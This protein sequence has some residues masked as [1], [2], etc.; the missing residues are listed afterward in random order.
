MHA[1]KHAC[2]VGRASRHESSPRNGMCVCLHGSMYTHIYSRLESSPRNRYVY[3]C[4]RACIHTLIISARVLPGIGTFLYVCI[5]LCI[6]ACTCICVHVCT[7]QP[8]QAYSLIYIHIY[9]FIYIYIYTHTHVCVP[10]HNTF[11]AHGYM[12]V[13]RYFNLL[14][15]RNV[16]RVFAMYV[17]SL[18][19][20]NMDTYMHV[21][22]YRRHF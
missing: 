20:Q 3:V 14:A 6:H 18:Y 4:M 7:Y 10:T 8:R 19:R 15:P 16:H 17:C 9:T 22:A 21:H 12:H 2:I 1:C 5:Y 11:L 13:Q